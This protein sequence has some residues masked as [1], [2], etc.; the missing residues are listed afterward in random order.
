MMLSAI[1]SCKEHNIKW[2]NSL[3]ILPDKIT[4]NLIIKNNSTRDLFLLVPGSY[5]QKV[6]C[7][8]VYHMFSVIGGF[9]I[10]DFF[11]DSFAKSNSPE[12]F[13]TPPFRE[14]SYPHK[15]NR[16]DLAEKLISAT[17]QYWKQDVE[18]YLSQQLSSYPSIIFVKKDS[19]CVFEYKY[20]N[21]LP[22]GDYKFFFEIEKVIRKNEKFQQLIAELK[23]INR[24]D[25]YYFEDLTEQSS[26]SVTLTIKK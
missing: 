15:F 18:M 13:K 22:K 14:A 23:R 3:N 12:L 5:I 4:Y 19:S 7:S 6:G 25:T 16:D 8:R 1:F 20:Q 21:N 17:T 24:V 2:N 11:C 10:Y 26:G 9:D